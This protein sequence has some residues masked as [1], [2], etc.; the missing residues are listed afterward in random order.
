LE[1]GLP[2]LKQ[3]V[4]GNDV[5]DDMVLLSKKFVSSFKE[6]RRV[7]FTGRECVDWFVREFGLSRQDGCVLGQTLLRERTFFALGDNFEL[8]DDVLVRFK[9]CGCGGIT[10]CVM[11]VDGATMKSSPMCM[12]M[13]DSVTNLCKEKVVQMR[14]G[15]HTFEIRACVVEENKR[16]SLTGVSNSSELLDDLDLRSDECRVLI[17]EQQQQHWEDSISAVL[18]DRQD[19]VNKVCSILATEPFAEEEDS[20]LSASASAEERIRFF[21]ERGGDGEELCRL[22]LESSLAPPHDIVTSQGLSLLH[23]TCLAAKPDAVVKV[24]SVCSLKSFFSSVQSGPTALHY[25]VMGGS[26][27]VAASLLANDKLSEE[28]RKTL[29]THLWGPYNQTALHLASF[30][31]FTDIV[32]MVVQVAHKANVAVLEMRDSFGSTPLLSACYAGSLPTAKLLLQS[33][34]K[35]EATEDN[36][37]TALM[38]AVARRFSDFV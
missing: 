13:F 11:G 27:E 19:V 18:R 31:G 29:L 32:S 33:G 7:R 12:N 24:L 38:I 37:N 20:K 25:A 26:K 23:M 14:S 9:L 28:S 3:R 21:A 5:L 34:A 8:E 6:E 35:I 1:K 22:V 17:D 30:L 10:L 16:R 2:L 36:G 15:R 4:W